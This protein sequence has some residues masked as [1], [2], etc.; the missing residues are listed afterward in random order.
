ME[1]ALIENIQREDLNPIETAQAYQQLAGDLR[2]DPRGD[3]RPGRQG[4]HLGHQPPPPARLPEE[5]QAD[6]AAGVLSMGH[7]RAILGL[8]GRERSWRPARSSLAKGLS[9][10]ETEQLVKRLA[11]AP[12]EAKEKPERRQKRHI[13]QGVRG[14]NPA[15]A[16]HQGR[17]S[18]TMAK[19][20]VIELHYFSV[21][22]T[23][24]SRQPPRCK[25][26]RMTL[27]ARLFGE[28]DRTVRTERAPAA[29]GGT[30]STPSSGEGTSFKGT[31]TFEG[32]VA[33]TA[34]SRARSSRRTR[35]WSAR[36]P[37]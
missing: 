34:G 6:V 20:G 25:G 26:V 13:Y 31:L 10:R 32:T 24:A 14:F 37:R 23:G 3:R 30:T 35:S 33:S 27:S 22:E 21:E 4:P 18:A 11:E 29:A 19:A 8:A 36:A 28:E 7:A 9:V 2:P 17:R 12:P 16:R 1:L 5:V 15:R